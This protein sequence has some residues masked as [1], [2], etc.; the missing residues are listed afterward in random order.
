LTNARIR[1]LLSVPSEAIWLFMPRS[2][3]AANHNNVQIEAVDQYTSCS[4][5]DIPSVSDA[6]AFWAELSRVNSLN[7]TLS[8]FW[9]NQNVWDR[10]FLDPDVAPKNAAFDDNA[11]FDQPGLAISLFEGHGTGIYAGPSVCCGEQSNQYASESPAQQRTSGK[12][13]SASQGQV[14]TGCVQMHYA[15]H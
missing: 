10:D 13:C 15:G 2:A 5:T 7:Y 14:N 9:P 8:A 3:Q 1:G 4:G 11:S 12:A 6:S